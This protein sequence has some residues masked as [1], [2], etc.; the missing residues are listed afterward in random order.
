MTCRQKNRAVWPCRL[1]RAATRRHQDATAALHLGRNKRRTLS[2]ASLERR[3]HRRLS[4][5][6]IPNNSEPTQRHETRHN[7]PRMRTAP[8]PTRLQLRG[9]VHT[10]SRGTTT[11]LLSSSSSLLKQTKN[12]FRGCKQAGALQR[13]VTQNKDTCVRPPSPSNVV[14][15]VRRISPISPTA[16]ASYTSGPHH[17]QNR[18]GGA[19]LVGAHHKRHRNRSENML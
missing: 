13:V 2:A 16:S 9:H 14:L 8:M 3:W 18:K 17:T 11:C 5:R 1:S 10:I 6:Q 12:H 15:T 4:R 19:A 7:G